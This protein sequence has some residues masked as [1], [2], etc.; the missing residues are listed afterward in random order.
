MDSARGAC[1]TNVVSKQLRHA[2][3]AVRTDHCGLASAIFTI[4]LCMLVYRTVSAAA[5]HFVFANDSLHPFMLQHGTPGLGI[6]S[7][8]LGAPFAFCVCNLSF[9][10]V[11]GPSP[12]SSIT[13]E[14]ASENC[15]P[16]LL[17]ARL[18]SRR[19]FALLCLSLRLSSLSP[20]PSSPPRPLRARQQRWSRIRAIAPRQNNRSQ[21]FSIGQT[22]H[23]TRGERREKGGE[24]RGAAGQRR[25]GQRDDPRAHTADFRR[26]PMQGGQTGRGRAEKPASQRVGSTLCIGRHSS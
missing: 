18:R 17:S 5:D 15:A 24:K 25:A 16:A 7:S 11:S 26:T 2:A 21:L 9:S 22:Q 13:A 6:G 19:L 12:S 8:I 3:P 4:Y 1:E 23:S 20:S 14:T 10:L